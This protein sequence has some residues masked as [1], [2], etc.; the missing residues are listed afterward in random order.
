[1]TEPLITIG[2][3][4]YREGEW[5]RE[6]WESVLAQSDDRWQAVI[7]MDGGADD[8]T[9]KVFESLEHPKLQK[10]RFE[11]NQGPYICRNKAFELT[12]TPYHFYLDADDQLTPKAI[13]AVLEVFEFEPDAGYV[14][15]NWR[16]LDTGEVCKIFRDEGNI[17][18]LV[19]GNNYTGGGAYSVKAWKAVGG[20]C[21]DPLLARGLSDYDFHLSLA[22]NDIPRIHSGRPFYRYRYVGD[23]KVS[24]R[25]A[26]DFYKKIEFIAE[27]HPVLFQNTALRNRLLSRGY[28]HSAEYFANTGDR[29]EAKRLAKLSFQHDSKW[30]P[31][32]LW[33]ALTGHP[34]PRWYKKL[35]DKTG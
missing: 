28:V 7:V 5:L 32:I 13:A 4:C 22:E 18:A 14:S 12:E 20:F 10:F 26:G 3:T 34:L 27:R 31:G 24:S 16:N 17:M 6:C 9:V 21:V 29:K 19:S 11:E 23:N 35:K 15:L 1:M 8:A 33:L 2:I 25:Y 30:R